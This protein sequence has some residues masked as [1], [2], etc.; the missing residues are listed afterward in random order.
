[1]NG[2]AELAGRARCQRLTAAW[3]DVPPLLDATQFTVMAPQ[4]SARG[5]LVIYLG[6]AEHSEPR[7]R[8]WPNAARRGLSG[9]TYDRSRA[10]DS[11]DLNRQRELDLA[12]STPPLFD[13]PIVVRL[14]L[15]RVPG[16]PMMLPVEVG[17]PIRGAIARLQREDAEPLTLCRSS[18][19]EIEPVR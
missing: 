3:S 6:L 10:R 12:F 18:I 9:R 8:E 15:W 11:D 7:P 19:G 14:E 2:V 17:T 4:P 13:A 16:G 1:V 5:P